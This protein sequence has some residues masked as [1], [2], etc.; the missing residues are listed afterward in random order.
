MG[1]QEYDARCKGG[2]NVVKGWCIKRL[3]G[4]KG[5][6]AACRQIEDPKRRA[7]PNDIR[8]TELPGPKSRNTAARRNKGMVWRPP[9]NR[10]MACA[11]SCSV[12]ARVGAHP[13]G[14]PEA[15]RHQDLHGHADRTAKQ[16]REWA[17]SCRASDPKGVIAKFAPSGAGI[18]G[19][20]IER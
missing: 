16:S 18:Q 12:G 15:V 17:R 1:C 8:E 11:T 4:R 19:R 2:W 20:A 3:Q 7:D 14:A 9:M 6:T 5:Y 10:A 13:A